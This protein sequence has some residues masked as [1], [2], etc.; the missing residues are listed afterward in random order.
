M[1]Y[2]M[3]DFYILSVISAEL[4]GSRTKY[5]RWLCNQYV[6]QDIGTHFNFPSEKSEVI[7]SSSLITGGHFFRKGL[8]QHL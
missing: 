8:C 4:T 7:Y 1:K 2:R 6:A 3:L 5:A